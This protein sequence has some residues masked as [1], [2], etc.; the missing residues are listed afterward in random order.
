VEEKNPFYEV[1][2][3]IKGHE[4]H[5]SNVLRCPGEKGSLVFAMKRGTGIKDRRDG[6]VYKN[7]LATYTHVHALGSPEWAEAIVRKAREYMRR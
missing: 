6:A 5:Y 7:V 3:E 4:F 2:T 1:G